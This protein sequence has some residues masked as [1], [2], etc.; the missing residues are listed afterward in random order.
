MVLVFDSGTTKTKAFLFGEKAELLAYASCPTR[1]MHKSPGIAE[2]R[3][4]YWWNALVKSAE[5]LRRSVH[6]NKD[7]ISAIGIS[8][9]GGTYVPLG[10]GCNPLRPGI[11][12]LDNRAEKFSNRLNKKYGSDYFYKRTG[13]CLAGWSPP[14]S[15]LWLGEKE[16]SL[17]SKSHRLS[18]VADYLNFKLTGKFYLDAT[19]AQMTCFYNI[20]KGCWDKEILDIAGLSEDNMP[21]VMPPCSAGGTVTEEAA[22]LLDIPAGIPVVAGGHDQYCASLGAGAVN[23]GDC[24]ISCGTSWALLV[25]TQHPVFIKEAGWVPGR[26]LKEDR[27]G[28]MAAISNGGVVLDW[29]KK[30]LRIKETGIDTCGEIEVVTDFSENKGAVRNINLSTTGRDIYLAGMKALS[31]VLKK[32][33]DEISGR[34]KIKRLLMV[35]GWT[36]EK[37]L[38]AMIE[39]CTGIKVILPE[40]NEAAGRGAA[41]LAIKRV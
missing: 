16:P 9:Q 35:G 32:R 34:I 6:W 5:E 3:A 20:V 36:R 7:S 14:A 18:F 26:H 2:Q 39:K 17:I 8:S 33:L 19:S 28:L 4:Y 41:L 37:A 31:A 13:H 21:Q 11:T 12:W 10:K 29:M 25:M 1:I 30:N 22:K 40:V 15:W 23:K 38:P 27:F 24:L